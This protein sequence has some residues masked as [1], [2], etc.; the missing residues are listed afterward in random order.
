M[1]TTRSIVTGRVLNV[2][3]Q[4]L[5]KNTFTVKLYVPSLGQ[6]A[7][8]VCLDIQATVGAFL[9]TAGIPG[10]LRYTGKTRQHGHRLQP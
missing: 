7:V 1:E 3:M 2:N 5:N 9:R 10:V 4:K 8:Q 6:Q